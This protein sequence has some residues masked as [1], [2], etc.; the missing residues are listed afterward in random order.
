M[1]Q[2]YFIPKRLARKA[3]FLVSMAQWVEAWGFRFIFW[4]MRRLS[5]ERARGVSAFAFGL[6]GPLSDKAKKAKINLAIAFPDASEEWREQTMRKIFR[7][8]GDSAAELIKLEQIWE[9][10]EQRIEFVVHPAAHELMTAKKPAIFVSAHVGPW[11]VAPLVTKHYNLTINTIY[12]PESNTVVAEL[13]HGLRHF[14][15]EQLIS[16]EAGLRPLI[17]ELTAGHSI[18]MAMDTR[19]DSGK[20]VPFFGRDALTGTSAAG[21]ALRTGAA[22]VVARAERLPAGHYRIT[23]YEPL[24]SPIPDAPQ[25]DQVLAMTAEINRHFEQWIRQYPEQ[26]ICLKRRWPKAH[27]L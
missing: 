9:E 25:K 6:V 4:L 23:V 21:L 20:L 8:L 3:P 27:K 15:G 14:L 12:A 18:N 1:P 17:K 26:W 16:S 5:V 13:M 19:L 7:S 22:L 11:Q 24:R 2:F 10:R